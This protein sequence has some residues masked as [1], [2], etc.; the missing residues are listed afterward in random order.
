MHSTEFANDI[1]DVSHNL[2]L[3]LLMQE[4]KAYYREVYMFCISEYLWRIQVQHNDIK[5]SL[6]NAN[7]KEARKRI[8]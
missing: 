7:M 4:K 2:L 6:W 3:K 8:E 1:N 5:I